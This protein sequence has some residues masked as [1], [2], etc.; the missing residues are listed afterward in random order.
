[1]LFR[2]YVKDPQKILTLHGDDHNYL[3]KVLRLQEESQF[4]VVSGGPEIK[5]YRIKNIDKESLLA[6]IETSYLED[7]ES[8]L[9]ITIAQ[10]LPKGDKLE[11]VLQ[12]CTE[13]GVNEFVLFEADRSPVK[14]N[15]LDN[16]MLR[17]QSILKSAV[18]QSRRN[19]LPM[20][21]TY[22]SLQE[23]LKV[24]KLPLFFGEPGSA[25]NISEIKDS[26]ALVFVVGPESG[27]A[28][29]ELALLQKY[30]EALS[31]G[32]RILR[33]ETAAIA[34]CAKLLL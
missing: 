27:F 28:P 17:W 2:V 26:G 14:L 21:K 29:A 32:K 33:T 25:K 3:H 31:L 4:E 5:V 7:N 10:A 12:K 19:A 8:P 34:V 23:F 13:L 30:G 16:K 20:I 6:E 1:M 11:Y 24:N 15:K 22:T 9:K 18:C